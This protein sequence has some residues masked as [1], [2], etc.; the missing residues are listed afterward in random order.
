MSRHC[1]SLFL[2]LWSVP[3]SNCT[4]GFSTIVT[5]WE[6]LQYVPGQAD[7]SSDITNLNLTVTLILEIN[8]HKNNSKY[9]L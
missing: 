4:S 2:N 7:H 1:R 3:V 9:S 5:G 8:L 6:S